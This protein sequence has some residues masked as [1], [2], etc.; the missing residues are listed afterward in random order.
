V[1]HLIISA[2]PGLLEGAGSRGVSRHQSSTPS[3][4]R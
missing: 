2:R 4:W 3:L 1:S